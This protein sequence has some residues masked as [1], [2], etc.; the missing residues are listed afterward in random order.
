VTVFASCVQ[1]CL[2]SLRIKLKA[3]IDQSFVLGNL[4]VSSGVL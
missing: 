3:R 2:M 4:D 1:Q